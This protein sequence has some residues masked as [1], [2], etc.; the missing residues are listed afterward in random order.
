MIVGFR[1][2]PEQCSHEHAEVTY[3]LVHGQSEVVILWCP[4]C[5]IGSK[6]QPTT[7]KSTSSQPRGSAS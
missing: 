2:E 4:D 7:M 6:W 3:K 1:Y 5:G